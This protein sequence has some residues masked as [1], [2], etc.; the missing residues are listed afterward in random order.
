MNSEANDSRTNFSATP[1]RRLRLL[2]GAA[3]F[4]STVLAVG[5]GWY[6]WRWYTAPVPPE[7]P[8]TQVDPALA[9]AIEAA[10]RK[11]QQ[12]PYSAAAW[13]ELGKLFRDSSLVEQAA[14]CFAQAERLDSSDPRWP[15][16]QGEGLQSREPDAALPA[17]QRA[18]ELCERA[19]ANNIAPRLRLAE[20]LLAKGEYAKAETQLQRA[21]EIEPDNP[22]VHLDLGL[23]AY[24]RD[25]LQ[26]SR[27]HLLRCQHSPFTQ[28]RACAQLAAVLQRLGDGK[29]AAEF[30]LRARSLPRDLPWPDPFRALSLQALVGKPARFEYLDHLAAEKRHAE[31][32]LLLREMER[33]G[34]DYR[35]YV[36]LGKNLAELGQF[37][38]ALQALHKAIDL[39]PDNVLAYYY[40]S[41]VYWAQGEQQ[42]RQGRDRAQAPELFRAAAAD[43]RQA[44]ARKPDFALA[45]MMLGLSL[46]YLGEH[47]K[48]LAALRRA[49]QCAPDLPDPAFH[50]GE[51]LAEDGEIAEA[52]L[53]LE[54]AFRLAP[55]DPRPRAAL[56][57][58]RDRKGNR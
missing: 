45:Q 10:R 37:Q 44:L 50:L 58:L 57:R 43:A 52:R 13:G 16:L 26:M 9:E 33:T 1:R 6:G 51:T 31:A 56:E 5:L 22:T 42:W 39:T 17:L 49:V 11:V 40:R 4:A 53:H 24:A 32:V 3:L 54:Q 36:G 55:D 18:V 38:E 29:A 25:D 2:V 35:V 7:M 15:Y 20:I 28:Q 34:P 46:K 14:I 21:Q 12:E 27:R 30:S 47:A 19:D 48:A 23:V 8:R 41:K